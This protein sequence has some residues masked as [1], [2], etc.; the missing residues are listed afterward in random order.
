MLGKDMHKS[1][2]VRVPEMGGIAIVVG[3]TGAAFLGI[4]L[5]LFFNLQFHL[6]YI[7]AALLT[8]TIVAIIGI[9]DDLFDMSQHVKAFLPLAA[10]MP[11]VAIA[12]SRGVNTIFIPFIGV[13]DFGLLYPFLLVPVAVAVCSNLTNMMAGFNGLEAGMGLII[14]S[15]LAL[16][17]LSHAQIEMAFISACMMGALTGFLL[18]NWYPA[19]VF[20]GDVGTLSI[21]A[22]LAAAVILSDYKAAG[23]ILVIPYVVDFFIKLANKFPKSFAEYRNGKLYTPR[24]QVKGLNHLILNLF[25]GLSEKQLVYVFFGIELVFSAI[26][27]A[28][29]T[30]IM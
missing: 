18:F 22:A 15:T 17:A 24:G 13:V 12:V 21:G 9:F 29:Y 19:K 5:Q 7:L 6:S 20:I 28:L 2:E 23:A 25:G 8:I 14:F 3:F 30:N 16:V 10:A 27:L 4:F 1:G 11:L 26:V